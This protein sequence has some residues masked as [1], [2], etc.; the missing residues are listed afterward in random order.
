MS[1]H[2]NKTLTT[3]LLAGVATL[4]LTALLWTWFDFS[5]RAGNELVF[6]YVGVGAFCLG[7]LPTALFTTKRLV[8]PVVVVS[9]L[10]LLSA[11]GTWSLVDSGLT[12]VD[13][14]PFGWFLLGW[15]VVAVV[16]LLVGGVEL[17]LRR[18]RDASG[19]TVG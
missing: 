18:V 10:Y 5:T 2:S 9:T 11:Y 19:P 14:T 7:V 12:P 4:A 8:S 3:S 15:P 1:L 17:G 13:P 16:A 6:A